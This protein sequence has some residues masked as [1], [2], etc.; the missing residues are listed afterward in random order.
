MKLAKNYSNCRYLGCYCRSR[1]LLAISSSTG[2]CQNAYQY[3]TRKIFTVP[4]GTG[5]VAF[6]GLLIE[7]NILEKG[8][9]F[10]GYSNYGLNWLN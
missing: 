10:N 4:A 7:D 5:R 9:N 3:H 1:G 8:M 2:L 6:E